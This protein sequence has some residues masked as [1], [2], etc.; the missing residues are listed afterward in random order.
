MSE[1]HGGWV[2]KGPV[3]LVG[4]VRGVRGRLTVEAELSIEVHEERGF[5]GAR[6]GLREW[7]GSSVILDRTG[8]LQLG[9]QYQVVLSSGQSGE[10]WV[11]TEVQALNEPDLEL[12]LT[13]QG[14]G[15]APWLP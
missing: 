12:H 1:E 14:I 15:R 6:P 4:M 5:D 11:E 2:Y 10:A 13:I 9:G 7:S 8:E 3:D